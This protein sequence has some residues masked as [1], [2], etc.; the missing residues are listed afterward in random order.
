[1]KELGVITISGNLQMPANESWFLGEN[2]CGI[3]VYRCPNPGHN[4]LCIIRVSETKPVSAWNGDKYKNIWK[5]SRE[6]DRIVFVSPSILEEGDFHSGPPT[7]FS[8]VPKEY[9]YQDPDWM[10][11]LHGGYRSFEPCK[12]VGI[13]NFKPPDAE[14]R[15]CYR[16]RF[17]DGEED[18]V[19]L[20][21]E[22]EYSVMSVQQIREL[23]GRELS[24]RCNCA[25]L[26]EPGYDFT[27]RTITITHIRTC[28]RCGGSIR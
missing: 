27:K 13:E 28:D 7:Y 26:V 12:I 15:A 2:E 5:L 9:I 11:R 1:M 3:I 21:P 18:L 20:Q 16:I 25:P 23:I 24:H 17:C 22:N 19:P 10:I 6:N 14:I 8:L 4:H